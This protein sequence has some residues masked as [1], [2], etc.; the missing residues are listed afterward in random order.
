MQ[1]WM[2]AGRP[3]ETE[4]EDIILKEFIFN[5]LAKSYHQ[6]DSRPDRESGYNTGYQTT[7]Y[8]IIRLGNTFV[9]YCK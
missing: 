2:E 6:Q 5:F 7:T 1:G 4:E 8:E 9:A 3:V